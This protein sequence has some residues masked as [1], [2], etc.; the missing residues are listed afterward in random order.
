MALIHYFIVGV[1]S[2]CLPTNRWSIQFLS[3]VFVYKEHEPHLT[4][5][6]Y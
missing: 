1:H 5:Q 6:E 3:V 2:L 4:Q